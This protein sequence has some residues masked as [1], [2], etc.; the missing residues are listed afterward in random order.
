MAR[1]ASS[2]AAASVA[3]FTEDFACSPARSS[4]T[5]SRAASR[6][7][8]SASPIR[9]AASRSARR[10]A[11]S[12]SRAR[13]SAPRA[14]SAASSAA[15]ALGREPRALGVEG[16]KRLAQGAAVAAQRLARPRHDGGGEADPPGD[17]ERRRAARR[18]EV[19]LV[20]RLEALGVEAHAGVGVAR[21]AE[22]DR[23]Q[24]VEVGRDEH[25]R[26]AR[27]ERL[28]DGGGERRPLARV[29]VRRDLVHEDERPRHG[30]VEHVLHRG[31]VGGE[32][33]EVLREVAALVHR[34]LHLEEEGQPR[35]RRGGD[36]QAGAEHEGGAGR[37]R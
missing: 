4:A 33:G 35:A 24:L 9:A 2:F 15:P 5:S 12:A 26:A 25:R 6:S 10:A 29:G 16:A 32:G 17:L 7:A 28:E 36:R 13:A 22:G 20:R 18:A 23:L 11:S 21:V 30:A 3:A 19:E 14:R 31:E 27:D 8:A 1:H 34:G 37:P